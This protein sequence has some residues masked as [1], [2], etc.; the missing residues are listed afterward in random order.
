MHRVYFFGAGFSKAINPKFPTLYELTEVVV[1]HF[2]SRHQDSPIAAHY[3][4]V[5]EQLRQN[6]ELMLSY[7][8]SDWPWKTTADQDLDVSLYRHLVYEIGVYLSSITTTEIATEFQIFANYL[9]THDHGIVTLNYDTLIEKIPQ[10]YWFANG[11]SINFRYALRIEDCYADNPKTTRKNPVTVEKHQKKFAMDFTHFDIYIRREHILKNSPEDVAV[12]VNDALLQ[13]SDTTD[14]RVKIQNQ[15]TSY[16]NLVKTNTVPRKMLGWETSQ[17]TKNSDSHDIQNRILKLHGSINWIDDH[18]DTIRITSGDGGFSEKV[19]LPL[20]V[21]PILDKMRHYADNRVRDIWFK[22][23]SAM[24]R[25]DEIIV[26]GFSF[27]ITDLSIRYM[28]QSVL[29]N[30]PTVRVVIIN[31]DPEA[32]L[33]ET[34][35]HVFSG[36]WSKNVDYR[37]CGREDSLIA[38]INSEVA[39]RQ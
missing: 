12:L 37:Y 28:F 31:R 8:F 11:T 3:M 14:E 23:H 25:A 27:P 38:Y 26:V 32:R 35:D 22:A 39:G 17:I 9:Q 6:L 5:P 19:R 21:P 34:Y 7:L 30:N 15:L 36:P 2:L 13:L 10:V 20:I 4:Q 18:S 29:H 33:R 1:N 24:E 16:L